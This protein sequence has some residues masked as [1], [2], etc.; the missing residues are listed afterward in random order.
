ML[1]YYSSGFDLRHHTNTVFAQPLTH[2]QGPCLGNLH[3]WGLAKSVICICGQLQITN[4]V[5]NMHPLI[6]TQVA[7][8]CMQHV[9]IFTT[10]L[11]K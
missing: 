3:S 8:K 10:A 7:R 4:H 9:T 2:S 11:A 1:L 5:V 6:T